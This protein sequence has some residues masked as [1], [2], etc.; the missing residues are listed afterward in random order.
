MNHKLCSKKVQ[1]KIEAALNSQSLSYA[2]KDALRAGLQRDCVDAAHDAQL[3]ADLLMAVADD[4]L[5]K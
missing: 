3:V 2:A 1:E 5:G 4:F